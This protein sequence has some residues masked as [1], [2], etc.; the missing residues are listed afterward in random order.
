M[1]TVKTTTRLDKDLVLQDADNTV[2]YASSNTVS[3]VSKQLIEQNAEAY[4]DLAK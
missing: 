1:D 2:A 3:A 4:G